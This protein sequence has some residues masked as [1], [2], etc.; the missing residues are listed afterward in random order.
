MTR[1]ADLPQTRAEFFS[2]DGV[3]LIVREAPPA[4]SPVKGQP[5]FIASNPIEGDEILLAVWDDGTVT[6]LNGHVDL[7]TGIR[8]ALAQIVAEE[9]DVPLACVTMVLGT[10]S[11]APNQGATIASASLQIHAVPLRAAA[12]QAREWLLA[13]ASDLFG[14]P[15]S[16]LS[17]RN[18]TVRL[19]E[20]PDRK[21]PYGDL[22][23]GQHVELP[24]VLDTPVK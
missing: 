4:P 15:A 6:A 17:L 18:G 2:A 7:G 19:I 1:R 23:R 5:A 14:A 3:L 12:A 8:T 20:E 21:V 10:T 9:L 13:R 16:G 24:L 11:M 22:L